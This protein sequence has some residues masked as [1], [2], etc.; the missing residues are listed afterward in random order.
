MFIREAL[1][2]DLSNILHVECRAFGQDDEANLVKELLNDP[3]AKPIL[4]L[5]AL[6]DSRTVGHILF[7][8]A[9]LT[10]TQI[11]SSIALLAPLAIVPDAQK[12]GI[13]GQLIKRGLQ[14][15][16]NSGVD[17]VFVLGHPEYY[18]RF[19]FTP[20]GHLGFEAPYPIPDKDAAAWMVQALKPDIIGTVSGKVVCSDKLNKPEYWRE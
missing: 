13:G 11:T 9:H 15:L 8:S 12:Q 18:P 17:L 2:S 19:G 20:A 7:T 3:S 4:S 10:N 1:D 5:I 6:D 14:L 16:S